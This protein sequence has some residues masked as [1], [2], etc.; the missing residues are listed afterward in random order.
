MAE[1]GSNWIELAA[2]AAGLTGGGL[3]TWFLKIFLLGRADG[4]RSTLI[5]ARQT[6]A[7]AEIDRL[8][9]DM[10]RIEAELRNLPSKTDLL[11]IGN[12]VTAL[13]ERIDRRIDDMFKIY[14]AGP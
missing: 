12:M 14:R 10:D 13:G 1:S 4:A 9:T 2:G 8:R 3:L 7:D 11:A 6:A 5:E